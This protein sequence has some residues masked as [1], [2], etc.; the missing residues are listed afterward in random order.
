MEWFCLSWKKIRTCKQGKANGTVA[1][2]VTHK[3]QPAHA[4]GAK[5][6]AGHNQGASDCAKRKGKVVVVMCMASVAEQQR[7]E[8]QWAAERLG[9]GGQF[10]KVSYL[11][12]KTWQKVL[13]SLI[14]HTSPLRG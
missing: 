4:P 5:I 9:A 2:R 12:R 10:A 3:R 11:H 1:L 13:A 7:T 8:T 14:M 6:S